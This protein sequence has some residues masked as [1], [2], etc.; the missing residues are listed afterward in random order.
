MIKD[1][2][3]EIRKIFIDELKIYEGEPIL[4]DKIDR[5]ILDKIIFDYY[6]IFCYNL[7]QLIL[8][9]V[10]YVVFFE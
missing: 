10:F 5:D 1:D 6:F 9:E 7:L 4:F 8:R 3:I 2:I